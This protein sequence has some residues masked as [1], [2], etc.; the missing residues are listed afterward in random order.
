[1]NRIRFGAALLIVLLILGLWI[2]SYMERTHF[3]Q[4]H[5]LSRAA[6][7]VMEG[8]WA[9]AESHTAIALREWENSRRL[10][11]ALSDHEPMDQV[12]G[13]FSQLQSFARIRDAVSYSSACLYLACRLEALGKSHSLNPENL[14]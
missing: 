11:A 7:L 9:G 8:N 12:E 10:T 1:M 14:L 13:F 2:S 5:H 3:S 4:A 6:E